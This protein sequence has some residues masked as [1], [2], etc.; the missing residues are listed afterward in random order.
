M[1]EVSELLERFRRGA[2]MVAVSITGAAGSELDFVPEHGKWSIRQ[3]V[4]HLAD[5]EMVAGVRMRQI[6]AE[7][8]PRLEAFD[9]DA[10]TANLDYMRRKS[11]HAL[12]SFRRIRGENYELLKDL[13]EPVFDREGVHSERGPMSLKKLL[14]GMA[15]HAESHAAQLRTRRAEFK[16]QKAAKS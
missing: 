5:S 1:S 9:Q 7:N 3:I 11:S 2:E 10:W 4:A 12:E 15:E 16:A 14:G 8:R 13:P 6:I